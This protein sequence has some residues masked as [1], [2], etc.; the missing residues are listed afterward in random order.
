MATD[1]IKAFV[2]LFYILM[3][4]SLVSANGVA[5]GVIHGRLQYPD[6]RPFMESAHISLNHDEQHTYSRS[7]GS[8]TFFNVKP[9]VHV[10]DVHDQLYHFSQIKCQ[11]LEESM[12][13]PTCIEYIFPGSHKLETTHPLVVNALASIEYFDAK[14]GFSILSIIKN[15]MVLMMLFSV[16]MM[17][18]MP[19]MMEG[20]DPEEK[21]KFKQQMAMQSDPQRMI[22][23]F[24]GDA[25]GG[26]DDTKTIPNK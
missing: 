10:V 13:K 6:K 9:G 17:Y 26:K 3:A 8:F 14:R 15:P 4:G 16:G 24:F 19:K 2:S 7:D 25:A 1:T 21:A 18:F 20:M 5:A 11:F 23:E 22:K 12:D